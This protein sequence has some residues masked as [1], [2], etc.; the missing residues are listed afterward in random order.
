[1]EPTAPLPM[2]RTDVFAP[3]PQSML[4]AGTY[5]DQFDAVRQR[6]SNRVAVVDQDRSVTYD[7]LWRT[8]AAIAGQLRARGCRRGD[9]IAIDQPN[10][11]AWVESFLGIMLAGGVAVPIDHKAP[12]SQ[13]DFVAQDAEA[14]WILHHAPATETSHQL[15]TRP[16]P[17]DLAVLLYTSGSTG[18]PKGV[19]ITHANLA[20]YQEVTA[21]YLRLEP[22]RVIRNLI[23]I[24]LWHSAGLNTQ[25]L[26]T[27]ALGGQVIV[28]PGTGPDSI[29]P[30]IKRWQPDVMFAVPVVFQRL[31]DA[32]TDDRTVMRSLVDVHF[33]AAST[34][35]RLVRD[36]S[37]AMPWARL[38]NAFGMTEISNVAL[39]LPHDHLDQAAGSVGFPVPGVRC[40]IRDPDTSGRG[41][42][43]LTGPNLAA[44]YWR[45]P[46][47]TAEAFVDGWIR[48]GDVAEIGDGGAVYL[49]DRIDDVIN[50]G[51]EKVY[52]TTVEEALLELPNVLEAA[53]VAVPDEHLGSRIGALLVTR[54]G[55]A[56]DY[57]RQ[58]V[59]EQLRDK[60]PRYALPDVVICRQEPLPR[61]SAGKV[62]K[63]QVA[64]QMMEPS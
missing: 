38:G 4:D 32:T 58:L 5:V 6:S 19:M 42:L 59:R 33:G 46:E 51:G 9:R 45:R 56:E 31:L 18:R 23:A 10:S 22:G 44:G 27:L 50:R 64:A 62:L 12:Q 57:D 15:V 16:R 49:R 21:G 34:P 8:A 26:P 29:L 24:P 61:G 53:V 13:K 28:A 48:S 63:N 47:L 37:R 60:L 1:M 25:L 2:A 20:S 43:Y 7:E 39:F 54:R 40:E 14:R 55:S 52:S 11:A 41:A 30:M 35:Q 36:L 3:V 17:T